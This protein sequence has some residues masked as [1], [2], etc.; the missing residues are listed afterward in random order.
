MSQMYVTGD[1]HGPTKIG[2]FSVD[3]VI[4]RFSTKNFPEQNEM[5]KTDIVFILG[6]FGCVWQAQESNEEKYAL[7]WLDKKPFTTCFIDGNHENHAR[8]NSYPVEEWNG[9][10]VHK[11]R[12]SVIHLMRGQAFHMDDV[13]IFTFGGARSHDIS[14]GILDP[15]KDA[16]K[17]RQW[18]KSGMK[19]FRVNGVSW[20]PEEMPSQDEMDEGIQ[21]LEK[22]NWKVDFVM[23]HDGTS[24][25]KA[26]VSHGAVKPDELNVYLEEIKQKLYY[27]KWFFG[28]L[29]EN[30][31]LP[32]N[33]ILLYEQ[34][35]RIH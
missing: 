3:G 31:N 13:R 1:T 11:I 35:I 24:S 17:I 23:T 25:V 28:H 20:W 27:K 10:K 30:R 16:K 32:D 15:V 33:Q 6:D 19:Y 22:E 9:G 2:M 4:P 5:D 21:S 26:F 12:P 34:I 29:H 18:Q 14:D 7:D 8:L